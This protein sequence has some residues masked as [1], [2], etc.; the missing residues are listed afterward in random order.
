MKKDYKVLT[1]RDFKKKLQTVYT[2]TP[3]ELR[4]MLV[5]SG[6]KKERI[7]M[8]H[9]CR[10]GH[11]WLRVTIEDEDGNGSTSTSFPIYGDDEE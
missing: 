3:G 9:V 4:F 11:E 10:S 2:L 6:I 8:A 7:E 5:E 1:E